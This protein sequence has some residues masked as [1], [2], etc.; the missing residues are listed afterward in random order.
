MLKPQIVFR[1]SATWVSRGMRGW[2]QVKTNLKATD[3]VSLEHKG[4][5]P[6]HF[7][8]NGGQVTVS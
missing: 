6:E 4:H 5:T 1:V 8:F 3:K 2:Q 7:L